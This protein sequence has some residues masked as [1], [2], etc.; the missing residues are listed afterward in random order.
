MSLDSVRYIRDLCTSGGLRPEE[1]A[2]VLHVSH[3]SVWNWI[4]G[5][6]APSPLAEDAIRKLAKGL[7]RGKQS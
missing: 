3:Q 7:G 6:A 2:S 1:V 5:K 4:N